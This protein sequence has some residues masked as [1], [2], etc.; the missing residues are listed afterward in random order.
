M[1]VKIEVTPSMLVEAVGQAAAEK[2]LS[3]LVAE[4]ISKGM[5]DYFYDKPYSK[6]RFEQAVDEFIGKVVG[7]IL[8]EKEPEMRGYLEMRVEEI[9]PEVREGLADYILNRMKLVASR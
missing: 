3:V 2:H 1:D 8:E 6:T 4:T 5:K 9:L 7:T